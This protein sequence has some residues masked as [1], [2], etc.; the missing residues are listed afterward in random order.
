MFVI[1]IGSVLLVTA[2]WMLKIRYNMTK[3]I[4]TEIVDKYKEL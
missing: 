1:I 3:N 2:L 4:S